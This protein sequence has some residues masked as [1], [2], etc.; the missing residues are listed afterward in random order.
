MT[1]A[2]RRVVITGA[3]GFLGTHL[4]R[5]LRRLPSPPEHITAVNLRHSP[6]EGV[7]WVTCDLVDPDSTARLIRKA[8]PDVVFHLAGVTGGT[9][10]ASLFS[11][12]VLA[13]QNVLAAA[14]AIEPSPRVIT[15]GSAAQYGITSGGNEVVDEQRALLAT[16]PYGVSKTLQEQWA[17]LY[18]N[19]ISL[20][21]VCVRP[22]NIIGPGQ[23][24]HLVPATFLSQ[25]CGVVAG[26]SDRVLVG[27]TSTERDFTDV[28][29]VVAAFWALATA[30]DGVTGE[31]FV[32]A[33][34]R[35]VRIQEIL[36]AAIAL[37]GR[38]IP[39]EVDPA[40]L[41]T[42]DVPSIVGDASKLRSLTGWEPKIPWRDSIADMWREMPGCK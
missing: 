35:P 22:F 21:V 11:V 33:S 27:N 18:A 12:N 38:A 36:D 8:A 2:P 24:G 40:R 41:Q 20:P 16:T 4:I 25:V 14:S 17:L 1:A 13:A 19:Q 31:I 30:P 37:S 42:Q 3:S 5:F 26:T 7:R 34:G 28:R 9:D 29:D 6:D 39:V 10:L 32:I 15:V 23:P